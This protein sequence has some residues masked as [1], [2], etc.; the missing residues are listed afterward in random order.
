MRPKLAFVRRACCACVRAMLVA[1][2]TG[3]KWRRAEVSSRSHS[4][5]REISAATAISKIFKPNF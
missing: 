1:C 3:A 4:A 5:R 2:E